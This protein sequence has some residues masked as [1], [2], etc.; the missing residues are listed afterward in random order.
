MF[1]GQMNGNGVIGV[2]SLGIDDDNGN[3]NGKGNASGFWVH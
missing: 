3:E 1:R 2:K